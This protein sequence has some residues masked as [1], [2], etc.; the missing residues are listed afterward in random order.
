MCRQELLLAEEGAGLRVLFTQA[1]EGSSGAV[2]FWQ[3]QRLCEG[4]IAAAVLALR[5]GNQ[6]VPVATVACGLGPV[7]AHP[8]MR[9]MLRCSCTAGA[10]VVRPSDQVDCDACGAYQHS[11]CAGYP[12]RGQ[13]YLCHR[14]S[15]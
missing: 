6:Q 4:P 13:R 3:R 9:S 14:C 7:S 1:D 2:P 12:Q 11:S 15:S 8:S 5:E 10:V